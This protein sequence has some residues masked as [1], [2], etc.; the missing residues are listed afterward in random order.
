MRVFF[1]RHMREIFA[2]PAE[3]GGKNTRKGWKMGVFADLR[4]VASTL[5]NNL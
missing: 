5:L 2:H 4:L 1:S 3:C